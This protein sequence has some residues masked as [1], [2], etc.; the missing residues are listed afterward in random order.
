MIYFITS[1]L[2]KDA[3]KFVLKEHGIR[4]DTFTYKLADYDKPTLLPARGKRYLEDIAGI[5]VFPSEEYDITSLI[6][7]TEISDT[8][9]T[10]KKDRGKYSGK[11][12][13]NKKKDEN[14]EEYLKYKKENKAEMWVQGACSKH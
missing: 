8:D 5:L 7:Y 13:K 6:G 10:E 1:G 9:D 11:R 12:S 2:E 4:S 3:T 14:H